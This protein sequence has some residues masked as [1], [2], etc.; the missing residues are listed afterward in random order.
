MV[1][2]D[3]VP[4]YRTD[5][6]T[7]FPRHTC[8]KERGFGLNDAEVASSMNYVKGREYLSDGITV[9]MLELRLLMGK[10]VLSLRSGA[11]LLVD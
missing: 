4:V 8:I 7:G 6:C 10:V 5:T 2:Q 9:N 11:V 3:I 1:S